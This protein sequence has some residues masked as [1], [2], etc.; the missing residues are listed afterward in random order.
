MILLGWLLCL[1][2]S[3]HMALHAIAIRFGWLPPTTLRCRFREITLQVS[4]P[5]AR[6]SSRIWYNS[7]SN[8]SCVNFRDVSLALCGESSDRRTERRFLSDRGSAYFER[9]TASRISP[10]LWAQSSAPIAAIRR[11]MESSARSV[12]SQLNCVL[13]ES[14]FRT[15]IN[16][17]T[18]DRSARPRRGINVS[19]QNRSI[20]LSSVAWSQAGF[21]LESGFRPL[22][23][24]AT[25]TCQCLVSV[26]RNRFSTKGISASGRVSPPVA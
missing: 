6:S 12:S 7:R 20:A 19:G 4:L 3:F 2:Q 8:S 14:L 13:C 25:S 23:L 26:A 9:R 21:P 17:F 18:I 10:I 1:C 24:R 5:A 16:S 15:S 22:T 11:R